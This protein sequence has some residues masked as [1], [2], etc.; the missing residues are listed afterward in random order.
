MM[1]YIH[2]DVFDRF[3]A[4]KVVV[5]HCGGSLS[6]LIEHGEASGEQGGG[7]VGIVVGEREEHVR[8]TSANLFVDSCAYEPTS[9]QL[10]QAVRRGSD[11]LWDRGARLWNGDPQS[12]HE[13][14][15]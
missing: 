12:A 7:S 6:R 2:T 3:P 11:G 9:W 10:H 1:L 14:A 8:D 13:A 4:L 15:V 5:C